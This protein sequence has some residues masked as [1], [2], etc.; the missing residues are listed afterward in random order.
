MEIEQLIE[1]YP[2]LYHMAE[3]GSWASI[4]NHGLLS[5]SALLDLF[6]YQG[7]LRDRI[8]AAHRPESIQI[9]HQERG[10]A[11]IRDQ[12][13]MS[14]AGLE[15]C[16]LGYTAPDWYRSLNGKVF[17]WATE[18]RLSRMLN[19]GAYRD[20]VH[21][22]LIIDAPAMIRRYHE[23]ITL[24]PMNSGCTKPYPHPRGPDTFLPITKYPF[25]EWRRRRGARG[26]PLVEVAV[27]YSVPDVRKFVTQVVSMR[28]KEVLAE[29]WPNS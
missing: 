6:Q 10:I 15:R 14:D 2:Q 27:E 26:D 22:V 4:E 3:C 5:T 13:P 16:L 11:V 24:S 18:E 12:K 25:D 29:I 7:P 19:A 17:F 1:L 20:M 9:E 28:N 23:R 8:E 21:D